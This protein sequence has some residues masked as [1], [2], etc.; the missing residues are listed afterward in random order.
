MRTGRRG[1]AF[2]I[3][4]SLIYK[5][6]GAGER[7]ALGELPQYA[8]AHRFDYVLTT[9]DTSG[10]FMTVGQNAIAAEIIRKHFDPVFRT[11]QVVIYRLGAPV[12]WILSACPESLRRPRGFAQRLRADPQPG[13]SGGVFRRTTHGWARI[14]GRIRLVAKR[15]SC[16]LSYTPII[17]MWRVTGHPEE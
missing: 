8:R 5:E 7:H 13:R 12:A 4:T 10:A 16:S 3:P 6:D 14:T 9:A 1:I 2:E 15:N 17:Q 11:G